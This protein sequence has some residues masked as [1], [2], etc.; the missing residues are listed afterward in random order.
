MKVQ[1]WPRT[2][3]ELIEM[4]GQEFILQDLRCEVINAN[5]GIDLSLQLS[6]TVTQLR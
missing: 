4:V 1:A 2:L 3:G 6:V 5:V